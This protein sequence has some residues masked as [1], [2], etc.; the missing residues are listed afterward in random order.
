MEIQDTAHLVQDQGDQKAEEASKGQSQGC[1]ALRKGGHKIHAGEK[2]ACIQH[3]D[4]T[5]DN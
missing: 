2:S 4:H 1:V 5:A 3:T